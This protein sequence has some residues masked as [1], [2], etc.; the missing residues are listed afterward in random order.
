[1]ATE[2]IEADYEITT[3]PMGVMQTKTQY[4]TAVNP[5]VP[6]IL[7]NVLRRFLEEAS[8]AES[9]FYYGWGAGKDK[10]EGPSVKLALALARCWGNCAVESLPVQDLPDAWIFTA[11]FVDLETGFTLTRQ[12]RQSKQW[13]VHGKHDAERKAD[14]RFQIGQSKAARNVILN[15]LPSSMVERGIEQ[16]KA[17]VRAA[18]EKSIEK[19][20]I[21]KAVDSAINALAKAGAT[22]SAILS[23]CMVADRKGITLEHLV[24]LKGDLSAIQQGQERAEVLFPPAPDQRTQ[25][26]ETRLRQKAAEAEAA[27]AR[28][29]VENSASSA[30]SGSL[31]DKVQ[32]TLKGESMGE[33]E[34]GEEYHG[35]D[36]REA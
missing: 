5:Q 21:A 32:T 7:K 33:L 8:M 34:A 27:R 30:E 10:I 18:I 19:H 4:L 31:Q 6:R 12:F 24:I 1:M 3:P 14:I 15:A 9:D 16:A 26:I 25:E 29:A 20:G 36:G 23:R 11:A 17:G 28:A 2:I 35:D 22:E 13:V